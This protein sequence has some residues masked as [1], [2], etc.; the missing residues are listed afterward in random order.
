MLMKTKRPSFSRVL[1]PILAVVGIIV[2]VVLIAWPAGSYG[3]ATVETPAR[4]T[5]TL[6][7]AAR[8]AGAGV[9]EPSSEI[10][11]IGTAVS[12]LV[13]RVL[14]SPGDYVS[15]GQPL[16][17][18]DDR[19]VRARLAEAEAG[20]AQARA[21]I[22]EAQAAEGTA[23]RNLALFR[24]VGD[25]AAVSRAESSGRRRGQHCPIPRRNGACTACGGAGRGSERSDGAWPLTV[26]APISGTILRAEIKAGEFVTAGNQGGNSTPFLQ[27]GETRPLHVRIDIDEDEIAKLERARPPRVPSRTRRPAGAGAFVRAEPLVIPKRSLTNS[28]AS[29]WT[30]GVL[31]VIFAL[32]DDKTICSASASRWMPS[33]PARRTQPVSQGR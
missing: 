7:N 18:I 11:D 16:F 1:L 23:S 21:A 19:Q 10:V 6:A 12:G 28:A 33:F 13:S 2:S 8:V 25:P 32:P 4:A 17:T 9:V 29:G 14:V 30:F 26:T 5:G 24:S 22:A 31:Q 20:I 3:R 15:R 27:M